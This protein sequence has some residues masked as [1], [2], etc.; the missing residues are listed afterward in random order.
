MVIPELQFEL[1]DEHGRFVARTDAAWPEHRTVGEFDGRI[2]FSR[3]LLG[4]RE[5]GNVVFA[6][7]RRED[8]IREL[9][10]EVV[11]WVWSDF[12]DPA[13]LVQRIERAFARAA[14]RR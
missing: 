1:R 13:A 4:N 14:T 8:Q 10:W 5:P 9:G 6:E 12:A 11:R 2:K 7:K 3:E